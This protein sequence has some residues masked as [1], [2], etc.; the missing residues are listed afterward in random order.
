MKRTVLEMLSH[1]AENFKDNVYVS[2]KT[3]SGWKGL[4]FNEVDKL[5]SYLAVSLMKE[6]AG[7]DSKIAVLS[8][9]RSSWIISEY[10]I[11]KTQ[12]VCVP[13][14]VKLLPQEIL[15]R[16]EHSGA[17]YIIVS[18]NCISKLFDIKEKLVF[19]DVRII[20]LDK[21]NTGEEHY[22]GVIYY[23]DM[24]KD[25]E[26]NFPAQKSL[27]EQRISGTDE[28]DTVTISYTSGTTGNPKGIMLTHLNYWSNSHD[29]VQ[30]FKLENNLSTLIILPL[31]HAFAHTIGFFCAT[32]CS[33]KLYFVDSRSGL[34]SSLKNI[35]LNI[36]ETTPDFLLTVPAITANFIKKIK[37]GISQKG[38]LASWL[39]SKGLKNGTAYFDDGFKK[40]SVWKRIFRYPIYCLADR[41][42][43][44]EVR[45]FF[46]GGMKFIIGGGAMLDIKQQQFFNCIGIPLMQG[47][48]QSEAAP[49]ISVNQRHKHKFGSSGGILSGIDCKILDS[50]GK[51]LPSGE[52]GYITVKGLN[53][54]KG[55]FK[56]PKATADVIDSDRR[57]NTGDLGYIDKDGFLFVTGREKALLIS[58]DGEKY[59]PE[60]IE[61]AIVSSSEFI[62]QC[63]LY[64]DH[65]K[66]TSALI[67]IDSL[68]VK[69]YV[70]NQNV[71]SPE[72]LLE[73]IKKSFYAF[74]ND[75]AYKNSFP[76]QWIPSVFAVLPETFS[77]QNRMMNS[78]MKVVRFKVLQ[79]YKERIAKLYSPEGKNDQS[80]NLKVLEEMFFS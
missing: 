23:E 66:Y 24:I 47:Y 18:R 38:R 28:N 80:E 19:S 5:S 58:A 12:A 64:N 46:G 11:L 70:S 7:Q 1:A 10:A 36:R 16:I 51:E 2:D 32:L 21:R 56:N 72:K 69:N 3:D 76:K 37:D 42:I 54:M 57:L 29:A 60:E 20:Y 41:L 40:P 67:T 35:P 63:V 25:G 79:V 71:K 74:K 61:D 53:V 43:F 8:E 59:S 22:P 55:Y 78:T 68:K 13:L 39:F 50:E 33:L 65:C 73:V 26:I 34:T 31:D 49:I 27:L 14:S 77:E 6:G 4:T 30:Y 15:F 48:G 45:N 9:G 75:P 17:K 62:N 52:K 44:S